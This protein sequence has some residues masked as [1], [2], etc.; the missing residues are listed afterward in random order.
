MNHDQSI[1]VYPVRSLL[2]MTKILGCLSEKPPKL[3]EIPLE[4]LLPTQIGGEDKASPFMVD[5][6]QCIH[7]VVSTD[8]VTMATDAWPRFGVT[9]L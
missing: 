3:P 7:G 2:Y 9:Y 1:P 4:V 8:F 5:R 6:C